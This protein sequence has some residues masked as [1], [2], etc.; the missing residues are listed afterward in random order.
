MILGMKSCWLLGRQMMLLSGYVN[1]L[2]NYPFPPF[3]FQSLVA[4]NDICSLI[5]LTRD[6]TCL[7]ENEFCIVK[8]F[9]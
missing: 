2:I 6:M 1:R 5:L 8:G 7:G 3:P 4:G 9:V